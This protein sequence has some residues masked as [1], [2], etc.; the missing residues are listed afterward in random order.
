MIDVPFLVGLEVARGG[1][2]SLDFQNS[3]V[4]TPQ[5][6][7]VRNTLTVVRIELLNEASRELA[8]KFFYNLSLKAVTP[9]FSHEFPPKNIKLA[10]TPSIISVVSCARP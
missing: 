9:G 1:S 8:L 6:Q 7:K 2:L 5:H 3:P 10:S 4:D